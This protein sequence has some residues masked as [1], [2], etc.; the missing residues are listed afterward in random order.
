MLTSTMMTNSY[1]AVNFTTFTG[2]PVI[3]TKISAIM[4]SSALK[5]LME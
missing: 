3:N 1:I 5:P 2:T 4:R